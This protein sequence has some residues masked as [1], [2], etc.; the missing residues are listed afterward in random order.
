MAVR[1]IVLLF[2]R[3]FVELFETEGA[4]EVLGMEFTVHGGYAT[5]CDG[6]LTTVTQ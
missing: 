3:A 4:Y 6:F 5:P 1:F 2:K